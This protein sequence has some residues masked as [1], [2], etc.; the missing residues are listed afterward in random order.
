M[1][2][3]LSRRRFMTVATA[4]VGAV[5]LGEV[6]SAHTATGAG[7]FRTVLE[8][9]TPIVSGIV[10]AIETGSLVLEGDAP[11]V[12]VRVAGAEIW[13]DGARTVTAMR[14]GDYVVA[15]GSWLSDDT[16]SAVEITPTYFNLT[17]SVRG[18]RGNVVST[19]GG[20]MRLTDATRLLT[21]D[22]RLVATRAAEFSP[23]AQLAAMAR[24]EAGDPEYV[25]VRLQLI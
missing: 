5:A 20:D 13:K 10:G 15:K 9:G 17:G 16:F 7:P 25:A 3:R 23:G 14:P 11:S 2:R 1:T 6:S 19:T 22:G 24:R 8:D 12:E 4:S 18:T 21:S